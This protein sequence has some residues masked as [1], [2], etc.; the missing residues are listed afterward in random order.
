MLTSGSR[1]GWTLSRTSTSSSS[2]TRSGP[3]PDHGQRPG[4]A[5]HLLIPVQSSYFALEGTDDL[6]ETV[7]RIKARAQSELKLLGAVITLHDK[8]TT[9]AR[10]VQKAVSAVFGGR[11][12]ETTISKSIRSRRVRPTGSRSSLRPAVERRLRVL[13][14]SVRRSSNVSSP[15]RLGLPE[16]IRMRHDTHF[17][18][19]LSAERGSIGR[20][21][22]IE[23]LPAEPR[24]PRQDL[25]DPVRA[26]GI[27]KE[28]GILEP[29]L[30][31]AVGGRYEII[32][33]SVAI[34]RPRRGA[35]RGAVRHSRYSDAEMMELALV[36]NLQRKDLSAFEEADGLGMLAEKYGYTHEMMAEKLAKQDIHHGNPRLDRDAGRR[37]PSLSAGRHSL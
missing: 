1:T 21:I 11:V 7:E 37:S 14:A 15:R 20:M 18:D 25:G 31:R 13:P 33:A 17:V 32:A 2:S 35:R 4:R 12:F 27:N 23:D 16:T 36:E 3:R 26:E 5:T 6:L 19:Q 10:D 28:K 29:I 34:G 9:L 8:R 22:P 30:V 24:Q